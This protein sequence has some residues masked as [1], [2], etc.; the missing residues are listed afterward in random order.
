M[1]AE[2]RV[3][4]KKTALCYKNNYEHIKDEL[5]KLDLLIHLRIITQRQRGHGKGKETLSPSGLKYINDKEIDR[6]LNQK[7][8]CI[9][10]H[11]ETDNIR[12][13]IH[14]LQEEINTK[15]TKTL[16]DGRFLALPQLAHLF[17]LSPLEL[18]AV[19]ITL[20]PELERKY[21]T[22]YAYVQD[23][24]TRK[25]PSV[26]L[27]LDLLCDSQADRWKARTLFSDQAPLF[28]IGILHT[29]NDP[30]SPSGSSGLAQLLQLDQRILDYILGKSTIDG[31]LQEC[32]TM[33][34]PSLSIDNLF[35]DSHIKT[36][37]LNFIENHCIEQKNSLKRPVLYFYGPAG[38]GRRDLALG[39]C[40]RLNC[41]MLYLDMELCVADEHDMRKLLD[42]AFREGLLLR[43]AL[44]IDNVDV[45]MED[46]KKIK[47]YMKKLARVVR[48][49]G[50]L[51]FLA[52]HKAWPLKGIFEHAVFHAIEFPMPDVPLRKAAWENVLKDIGA[53]TILAEPLA[54][55]FSLTPGQIHN[56]A[57]C[58]YVQQTLHRGQHRITFADMSKSCRSQSNQKLQELSLKIEPRYT[59]DDI[60]LPED[61]LLQIKEICN[62]AK[63]RYC[64][65]RT[66]GFDHKLSRGK[67]LSVLFS[68][69]SG[70][71]KTM[72]AEVMAH[73][74]Q[75]DLYKVDLSGIVSKYIGETEKNLSR[76]FHEADTSNAILFFDEA[77]ALFGKRTEISDAHDRYANIETSYLL[78][79]MEEYEGIIILATNLRQNM[80]E[81]FIRRIRFIVEFPFPDMKSRQQIWKAQFPKEAPLKDDIDYEFLAKK[82]LIPGGNI[83]NIVLNAAFFAAENGKRIEMKQIL[84]GAK[85]EFE[86]IG[87]L[88]D[89]KNFKDYT[90]D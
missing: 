59:W 82:F 86:K 70:T 10:D 11:P 48:L 1:I 51:T 80:D 28:Y 85:R 35:I 21:D 71:G 26:D 16:T 73:D 45:V 5:K 58:V 18:Q 38:V 6:L 52:G 53:D 37:V 33:Y 32:V 68:G 4:H 7:A 36:E 22:L 56:A 78:Q 72:A 89:E 43:A 60:I 76:I 74:L 9:P 77:D 30:A 20:A 47:V 62:Q 19:I 34:E 88:W 39:V 40:E 67:G 8:A 2:Q 12:H 61:K 44:Y 3:D 55:Q 79:K 54:G 23:D 66:W 83:K 63:H 41:P 17:R 81:A 15:V 46:E 57:E 13:Y 69:P 50:W 42:L 90:K 64:V 31:R 29:C 84:Q 49:Y 75:R 25:R 87:K 24:I 27:V 65:F 14:I